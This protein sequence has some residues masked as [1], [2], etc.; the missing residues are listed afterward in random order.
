MMIRDG[1][2]C[3]FLLPSYSVEHVQCSTPYFFAFEGSQNSERNIKVLRTNQATSTE[4]QAEFTRSLPDAYQ[5]AA[6]AA[7]PHISISKPLATDAL[8]QEGE[9]GKSGAIGQWGISRTPRAQDIQILNCRDKQA[10]VD[11]DRRWGARSHTNRFDRTRCTS[12]LLHRPGRRIII[13]HPGCSSIQL[14]T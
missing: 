1:L 8:N 5:F 6:V 12:G 11:Y 4:Q 10:K 2:E 13:L 14:R 7:A 3:H 9:R